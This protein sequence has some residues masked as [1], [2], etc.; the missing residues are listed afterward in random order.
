M[1]AG[2]R[3]LSG[4]HVLQADILHGEDDLEVCTVEVTVGLLQEELTTWSGVWSG[5]G[6][7][8]VLLPVSQLMPELKIHFIPVSNVNSPC[9]RPISTVTF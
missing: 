8:V 2:T 9:F 3:R 1:F 5:G 6:G 4:S 7:V